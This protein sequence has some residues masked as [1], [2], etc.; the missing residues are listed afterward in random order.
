M[1]NWTIYA[2]TSEAGLRSLFLNFSVFYSKVFKPFQKLHVAQA[3]GGVPLASVL[4]AAK[5]KL[6]VTG[7]ER[8]LF[9]GMSL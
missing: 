4:K 5:P 9:F 1:W 8:N 2:L 6:N 7:E 3:Y